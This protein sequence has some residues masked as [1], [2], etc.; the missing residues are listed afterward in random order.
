MPR[1]PP[2]RDIDFTINLVPRVALVSKSPYRMSTLELMELK[3]Q[4]HELMDNEYIRR[5]VSPW[6]APMLFVKR[7]DGTLRLCI[8]YREVN[9]VT[10]KSKYPLPQINNLFDEMKGSTV[11]TNI[12]LRLGYNQVCI[13]EED[14]HKTSFQTQ[15]GHYALTI[16]PFYL[17]NAPSTFMCLTKNVIIKYLNKFV[18]SIAL[19]DFYRIENLKSMFRVE[20]LL[21]FREVGK[22]KKV[23]EE[24]MKNN[25]VR[26]CREN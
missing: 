17:T 12:D 19:W 24:I 21:I 5:T 9:K 6:G 7:K 26:R 13:T 14:I 2:K 10:F 1:L 8:D 25:D 16:V 23:Y 20:A 3:L 4:L 11:F 22:L 15:Y 18:L